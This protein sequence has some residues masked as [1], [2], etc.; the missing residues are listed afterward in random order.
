[1]PDPNLVGHRGHMHLVRNVALE[2]AAP[3]PSTRTNL[4][5]TH[6][7]RLRCRSNVLPAERAVSLWRK[8]D[9]DSTRF[10]SLGGQNRMTKLTL[11]ARNSGNTRPPSRPANR[12]DDHGHA[13]PAIGAC[14]RT[15]F[16]AANGVKRQRAHHRGPRLACGDQQRYSR[17]HEKVEA[18][19]RP[20]VLEGIRTRGVPKALFLTRL[21]SQMRTTDHEASESRRL[22][23]LRH[24]AAHAGPPNQD[25]T[26][27][28]GDHVSE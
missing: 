12:N 15:L 18:P 28:R 9:L 10:V 25:F 27:L 24:L 4:N 16:C 7:D 21:G 13:C 14:D 11:S 2:R 8:I 5:A 22:A 1:M 26:H 23:I 19:N 20:Q 3:T 6:A 17:H